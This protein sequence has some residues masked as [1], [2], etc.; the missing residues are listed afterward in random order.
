MIQL[1][2]GLC[3]IGMPVEDVRK[4]FSRMNSHHFTAL[5]QISRAADERTSRL[6]TFL[7]DHTSNLSKD[8]IVYGFH[9][10]YYRSPASD[11]LDCLF[12]WSELAF[13]RAYCIP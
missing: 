8:V 6:S 4:A 13:T 9:I 3:N 7:L 11:A 2:L 10:S 5:V 1:H 12:N